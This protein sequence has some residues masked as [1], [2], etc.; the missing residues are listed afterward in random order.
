MDNQWSTYLGR[1]KHSSYSSELS[2]KN[3]VQKLLVLFAILFVV[4]SLCA[5]TGCRQKGPDIAVGVSRPLS[6][7]IIYV[8]PDDS[9]DLISYSNT[10]HHICFKPEDA[11]SL[12]DYCGLKGVSYGEASIWFHKIQSRSLEAEINYELNQE[13]L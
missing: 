10:S 1:V 9:V 11:K 12:I 6:N 4:A 8:N 7:G 5:A 3:N 2:L 13:E